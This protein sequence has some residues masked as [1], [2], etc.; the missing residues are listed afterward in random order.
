MALNGM[1]FCKARVSIYS[2]YRFTYMAIDN[3]ELMRAQE[4]KRDYS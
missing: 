1:L 4:G 3:T 2:R